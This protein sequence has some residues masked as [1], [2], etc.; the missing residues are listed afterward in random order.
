MMDFLVRLPEW[1]S[2]CK[3]ALRLQISRDHRLWH[4]DRFYA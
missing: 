3:A 2:F 1:R 4:G